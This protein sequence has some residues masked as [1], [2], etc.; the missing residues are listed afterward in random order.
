M[1]KLCTI[2]CQIFTAWRLM[3]LCSLVDGSSASGEHTVSLFKAGVTSYLE[4]EAICGFASVRL[5]LQN[6]CF[7]ISYVPLSY[8]RCLNKYISVRTLW[9]TPLLLLP[10]HYTFL[11]TNYRQYLRTFH[12][13]Q[14]LVMALKVMHSFLFHCLQAAEWV[15]SNGMFT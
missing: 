1:Y 11:P 4:M 8:S 14:V 6:Y 9:L 3:T 10:S 2:K 7:A 12:I 5:L 15:Y 13:L